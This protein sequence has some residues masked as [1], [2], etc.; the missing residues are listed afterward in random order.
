M[1]CIRAVTV[2]ISRPL[3]G[4]TKTMRIFAVLYGVIAYLIF[5]VSFLYAIGFVE[6]LA[7]PKTI[8]S[9]AVAPTMTA[10]VIDL[11]LLGV[12]AIQHSLMARPAFKAW[13][14]KI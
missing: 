5:F 7:V 6:D 8:D 14:T 10:V 13:W 2:A 11:A 9:G 3:L 4:E 1:D 12:F